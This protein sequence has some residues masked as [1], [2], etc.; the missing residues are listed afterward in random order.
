MVKQQSPGQ[1]VCARRQIHTTFH[2]PG[3][4]SSDEMHVA[5]T[6]VG[7]P[8]RE[9][10]INLARSLLKHG[11]SVTFLGPSPAFETLLR[12]EGFGD[13]IRTFDED[14]RISI[15]D[16][17]RREDIVEYNRHV[18]G[19]S[20]TDL[21]RRCFNYKHY[22]DV[23]D[24]DVVVFWN[25][26]DIGHL[27]A[28]ECDVE[29]LY[30]ENGYLPDTIQV[31]TEGVN[32]N[33]SFADNSYEEILD[34]D[35]LWKPEH[36][37]G[38]DVE[39]VDPLGFGSK[40]KALARTRGTRGNFGWTV[41]HEL[42]K[43][44]ASAR[45]RFVEEVDSTLTDEYVFVPFQVHDDTQVL[46]NSPYVDDMY[47]FVDLVQE[48]VVSL[49]KDVD[50]VVKEHP[51]DIGRIDYSDL[52]RRYPETVWLRNYPIDEVINGARAVVTIN[53]SVGMQAL[54][55][56]VPVVTVGESFYDENPFVEH[57]RCIEEVPQAL[58]RTL[59]KQLDESAVD[60]YLQAFEQRLFVDGSISNVRS[61]TL[62]QLGSVVLNVGD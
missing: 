36:D 58:E 44:I 14:S 11:N 7:P 46:Y 50:I 3:G 8:I 43:R 28:S 19:R 34:V 22:F 20:S 49:D 30:M 51:A 27:V 47:E 42:E 37:V 38:A 15:P 53:S 32:K 9:L 21:K 6:Q 23:L 52:R 18:L 31:D 62:R 13:S 2:G 26:I 60:E 57:P 5:L 56:Y 1:L 61:E 55:R 35:P 16:R 33:A 10:W 24:V 29:T 45:R 40:V 17:D 54:N 41:R 39:S 48:S 25:D 4:T 59:S 12:R